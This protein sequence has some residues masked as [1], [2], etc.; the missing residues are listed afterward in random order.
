[1]SR[2]TRQQLAER[3]GQ[4]VA[5]EGL[6][7]IL[8]VFHGGEP[9]LAGA[10][11]IVETATWIRESASPSTKVDFSLQTNG[12]L[13]TEDDLRQFEREQ[14]GVSLSID[15]PQRANDLHRLDHKGRSSFPEVRSALTLLE[16]Y[17]A[18]YTGVI[19]VIDP[20]VPASELFEFFAPRNPPRMD[21]LL[22]DATYER[23]PPG[24]AHAPEVYESWLR[25]AFDLWFDKYPDLQVRLFDAVLSGLAGLPSDT[26]ALG[27]GDV[28]LLTIETDGTY[29]DLDVLKITA[30]GLTATGLALHSDPIAAAAASPAIAKHRRLLQR[31]GLSPKCNDCP[32]VDVC[33]GGA[34]PHRYSSAGFANPTIYCRELLSLIQHAQRRA[35]AA[36]ADEVGALATSQ[37]QPAPTVNMK[38][39][40]TP[41]AENTSLRTVTH[42]WGEDTATRFSL[43]L[44]S[45]AQERP[46]LRWI[47]AKIRTVSPSTVA[48]TITQ[49]SVAFW[50]SVMLANHRGVVMRAIDGTPIAPVPEYLEEL[51]AAMASP[52][53]PYPRVH[54]DDPWLRRPFGSKIVFEA[55]SSAAAG[56]ETVRAAL[57]IIRQWKPSLL[58]EISL[59][60]PD[61]QF[62]H[63]PSADADESVSFSDDCVPGALYIGLNVQ[64]RV[65][66]PHIVAESIIHEHRHQKLYLLQRCV[67][68]F[69]ADEPLVV[70]PWRDDP[71]PPSGLL[72]AIF[73]FVEIYRFWR[74]W[75]TNGKDQDFQR[76]AKLESELISGRLDCGFGTLRQTALTSNGEDLVEVLRDSFRSCQQESQ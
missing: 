38:E 7:R 24:R 23:P 14:I 1:M 34:V 21:F 31:S 54:R 22:P 5:K 13:L 53:E 60:C 52:S 26:D 66:E 8:V 18:I 6:E 48:R 35:R 9:L 70:S 65:F 15:G 59:L 49:P 30:P 2:E 50:T 44:D 67:R 64:G 61:I 37:Q 33:G 74:H 41:H 25:D 29:H 69:D 75:E 4:Y 73:V 20:R 10:E 36:L 12:V 63:D 47:I 43:V 40:E 55:Q 58:D 3:I 71:R 72:H 45:V 62:I 57:E 42:H 11:V 68:L 28:S 51:Y 17:P 27:F 32:V 76:R 56:R 46:D 16:R 39:W 19:S